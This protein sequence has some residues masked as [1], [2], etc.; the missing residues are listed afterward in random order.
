M[1]YCKICW[2]LLVVRQTVPAGELC[3]I[4]LE[5]LSKGVRGG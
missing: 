3:Y 1:V 4:C 2:S 5:Y